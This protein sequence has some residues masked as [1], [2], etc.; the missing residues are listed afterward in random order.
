MEIPLR[1]ILLA[2]LV[3]LGFAALFIEA[4]ATEAPAAQGVVPINVTITCAGELVDGF[5]I[6]PYD[7]ALGQTLDRH[8]ATESIVARA[9]DLAHTSGTEPAGH[10]IWAY[11]PSVHGASQLR[12]R[13]LI[14]VVPMVAQLGANAKTL[15]GL[16]LPPTTLRGAATT[17]APVGG[18]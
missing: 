10:Q 17:I 13:K 11:L 2:G 7:A 16:P 3:V 5:T 9:E 12:G 15:S 6:R 14:R 8:V 4:Q 1:R 18:S